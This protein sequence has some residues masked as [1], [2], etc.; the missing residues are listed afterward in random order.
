VAVN[1]SSRDGIYLPDTAVRFEGSSA[2][3][4]TVKESLAKRQSVQVGQHI[5]N[6]LEIL[7][8]VSAGMVVIDT[9][10]S[11]LRDGEPVKVTTRSAN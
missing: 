5:G 9:S 8:G 10:A 4:F 1:V 6:K 7:D 2:Y 3:V 11:F